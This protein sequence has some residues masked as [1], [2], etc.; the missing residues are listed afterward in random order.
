MSD[1]SPVLDT[2][3]AMTAASLENSNL[4]NRELM[5]SRIAA[6]AAVGAPA[7][8]YLANIGAAADSGV[9]LD[10]ARGV[11]TAIAPIIGT[12][13]TVTAAANISKALGFVILAIEDE[14]LAELE[15][16]SD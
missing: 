3:A 10:D 16:E 6:L 4:G 14:L 7:V 12:A 8:S 13:Q 2:I 15:A 9:T 1:D 11:L 5:L